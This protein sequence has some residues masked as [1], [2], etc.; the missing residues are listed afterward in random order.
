M[1]SD[2]LQ[3]GQIELLPEEPAMPL[4]DEFAMY[5]KILEQALPQMGDFFKHLLPQYDDAAWV[6]GRLTE[7][8]PIPLGDKQRI[9]E[10]DDPL[11]RLHA[12]QPYM[13]SETAN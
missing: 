4:P 2:G 9:L 7:V 1:Q 8:L 5:G 13:R 10:M 11:D 3:V 12:L 6:S